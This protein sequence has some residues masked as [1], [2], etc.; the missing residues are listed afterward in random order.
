MLG[1]RIVTA[2]IGM[3]YAIYVI[4]FG[5]WLYALTIIFIAV[6]AWHEFQRMF[7]CQNIRCSYGIGLIS[8]LLCCSAAW[9]GNSHETVGI[10]VG[11]ILLTLAYCV[12]LR[13]KPQIMD[14]AV[15]ILGICYVGLPFAHLILLR[16][17]D[18][19]LVP[20]SQ[21]SY[22]TAYIWI[23]F[24][25]T[26]ASDTFA[27]FIGSFFG[28]R[29]LCPR[30]SPGKTVEGALG[31]IIGSLIAVAVFGWVINMPWIHSLALGILIGI[32]APVGD[33]VE[34]AMKRFTKVKDSG[35]LLPGHG[36]VLD[37]F[38]S[39]LFVVPTVYY[40]VLAFLG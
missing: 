37:R 18:D 10:L 32:V 23:T 9:L 12:L 36:G 17:Y 15:T 33:L 4:N 25:G 5:Q 38:D 35:I 19:A 20:Q 27:Y 11:A 34:S 8:V 39:M 14:G 3:A 2:L 26:W 21:M 31:G 13:P 6:L 1:K 40:Y 30:I 16:F 7:T 24:I 28:K 29:K 22:G